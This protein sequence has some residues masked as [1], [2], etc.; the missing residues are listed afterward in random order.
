M[1]ILSTALISS[2]SALIVATAIRGS[3]GA[4]SGL[5]FTEFRVQCLRGLRGLRK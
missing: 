3:L 1:W 2:S 5:Q 4:N